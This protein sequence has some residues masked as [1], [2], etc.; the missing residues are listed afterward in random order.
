[1]KTWHEAVPIWKGQDGS[2]TPQ[3]L[4]NKKR[5]CFGMVKAGGMELIEL[6]VGNPAPRTPSNGDAIAARTIWVGGI[7]VRLTRSLLLPSPRLLP[8][9]R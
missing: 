5:F 3:S 8:P 7:L 2:F 1:M 9:L 6:K 4:S